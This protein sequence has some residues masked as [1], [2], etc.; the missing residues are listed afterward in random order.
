MKK[1]NILSLVLIFAL[2]LGCMAP[3]YA[4][5]QTEVT[6]AIEET[7]L[8]GGIGIEINPLAATVTR[9]EF[10]THLAKA[11]GTLVSYSGSKE[12]LFSDVSV[13]QSDSPYIRAV[14][15]AGIMNGVGDGKF[16]PNASV[17]SRDAAVALV[18]LAG[19][20]PAALAYGGYPA[21]YLR[22]ASNTGI[23]DGVSVGTD[24][25]TPSILSTMLCNAL[26]TDV[27][28]LVSAGEYTT[29]EAR[30]DQD[31]LYIYHNIH[32]TDAIVTANRF[33]SLTSS[34]TA[35]GNDEI[36]LDKTVYK[37]ASKDMENLLGMS[38]VAYYR[39]SSSDKKG[40]VVAMYTDDTINKTLTLTDEDIESINGYTVNYTVGDKTDDITVTRGFN[41]IYN[42]KYYPDGTVADLSERGCEL[43]FIDADASNGYE[44]V[45]M[46]HGTTLIVTNIDRTAYTVYGEKGAKV[47]YDSSADSSFFE[48]TDAEG[49]ELYIDRIKNGNVLTVFASKDSQ[50]IKVILCTDT[51]SGTVNSVDSQ[52]G[53]V[54]LLSGK[55]ET[56]YTVAP[57]YEANITLG[58]EGEFYLD[59]FGRLVYS[60][61]LPGSDF[62]YGYLINVAFTGGLTLPRLLILTSVD[63]EEF[64]VSDK[65]ALDGKSTSL[66]SSSENAILSGGKAIPQVVRYKTDS[67]GTLRYLDTVVTG[68]GDSKSDILELSKTVTG[69]YN[70]TV[71]NLSNACMLGSDTLFVKAPTKQELW[72]DRDY[73]STDRE[74]LSDNKSYTIKAYDMDETLTP[75]LVV[76]NSD[77]ITVAGSLDDYSSEA[78]VIEHY[79]CLDKEG[80]A[81]DA[82][83]IFDANGKEATLYF[84]SDYTVNKTMDFGDIILYRADADNNIMQWAY[85]FDYS[86]G[87]VSSN[88]SSYSSYFTKYVGYPYA[89]KDS[90]F[91]F[92]NIKGNAALEESW[93]HLLA[94]PTEVM[95]FYEVDMSTKEVAVSSYE[96]VDSYMH[97]HNT[98][99]KA[100]VKVYRGGGIYK[101]FMVCYKNCK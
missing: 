13:T 4:A 76:Y 82:L 83:R 73:Y 5:D 10:A 3:G 85:D 60:D 45:V 36:E 21:G 92:L 84:H 46:N 64:T 38:V 2:T 47:V 59:A 24:P 68:S 98:A 89:K 81:R 25:L 58:L 34:V 48:I 66:S 54:T 88:V 62:E 15:E 93:D 35:C 20:E 41:L 19:Y 70:D 96:Y 67:K 39:K 23:L 94:F 33:T 101:D 32:R 63:F 17:S 44:T 43:T 55:T 69:T 53:E 78:I 90:S 14:C 30:K 8:L 74:M 65:F 40:T 86:S 7:S 100:F 87:D 71:P 1:Y 80:D 42:G 49:N 75:K 11:A 56:V 52:S 57:G 29:Y 27:Y 16:S 99:N 6:L 26:H 51:V 9:G 37:Y 95:K 79:K 50:C 91:S 97:S 28:Q 61:A 31:V 77:T 72:Y 22:I 18:R 12:Q